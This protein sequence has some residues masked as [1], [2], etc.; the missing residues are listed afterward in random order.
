M[1]KIGA[2]LLATLFL[3]TALPISIVTAETHGYLTYEIVDDTVTI[4]ACDARAAGVVEIPSY[5]AEYP[6]TAIGDHAFYDCY[7]ITE[8]LI[9]ESVTAIGDYALAYCEGLSTL[10]LPA[11][12]TAIGTYAFERCSALTS[13]AV[14][15]EN[16]RYTAVDGVLFDRDVT[17]LLQY[18]IG[19]KGAYEIPDT[20]THIVA[21][22][23]E[24]CRGLTE[25]TIP[26]GVTHIDEYAFGWCR[27]LTDVYYGG[28]AEDWETITL[29]IGNE[30]LTNATWHFSGCAHRY[31]HACDA[32]CNLCGKTRT[33]FHEY[34]NL[35]DT[36]CNACGAERILQAIAEGQT[37]Q[38]TITTGGIGTPFLF[39][40]T[41]SGIYT[42][43]SLGDEDTFGLITDVDETMLAYNNDSNGPGFAVSYEMSAG[44]PYVLWAEYNSDDQVGSFAVR[45]TRRRSEGGLIYEI[46]DAKA[47]LVGYDDAL[48]AVL[49]IPSSLGGYP[50]TTID[51]CAFEYCTGLTEVIIPN[52]VTAI[53]ECAFVNCTALTKAV[54]SDSVTAIG[55]AQFGGC[56]ALTTVVLS[57]ATAVIEPYAFSYCDRLTDVYYSGTAEDRAAITVGEENEALMKAAWHYTVLGDA[58]A[59]GTFTIADAIVLQQYLNGWNVSVNTNMVDM[60]HDDQLNNKDLVLLLRSLNGWI[61]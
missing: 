9:P 11:G 5:I 18:P 59:D 25:I 7:A 46:V 61:N 20:V 4:V 54:L 8:L 17:A 38:A 13:F 45:V 42:F 2:I 49:E 22:A 50:V 31:D 6:V 37:V 35:L 26:I 34:D 29:G 40:P 41:D 32:V 12:I 39:T 57:R 15:E 3:L 51:A 28:E 24:G 16:P 55:Y 36:A 58:N 44:V 23:F 43:S 48:P 21:G 53:G 47:V 60:N 1:K 30:Y 14:A 10:V 19:R 33:V 56:T 52:N 27:A